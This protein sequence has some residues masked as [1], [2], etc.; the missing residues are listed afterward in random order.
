MIGGEEE[1]AE[2]MDF[3]GERGDPLGLFGDMEDACSS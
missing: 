3:L 1:L 2:K